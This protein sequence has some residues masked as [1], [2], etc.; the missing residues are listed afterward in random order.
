MCHLPTHPIN[1]PE[2]SP[3]V[4]RGVIALFPRGRTL[5]L[6]EFGC[7]QG[8]PSGGMLE[9]SSNHHASLQEPLY[10][11]IQRFSLAA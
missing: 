8:A 1:P 2:R 10:G 4:C 5:S 9:V 7:L 11:P 3:L 6:R